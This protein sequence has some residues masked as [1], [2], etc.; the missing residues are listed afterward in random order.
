MP[1]LTLEQVR[2]AGRFAYCEV[3]SPAETRGGPDDYREDWTRT[4][5][6]AL[7]VEIIGNSASTNS[8]PPV[9]LDGWHHEDGC[10]CAFCL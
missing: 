6:G 8:M 2:E 7:D 5:K 9:P 3:R 1:D 10:D 4:E